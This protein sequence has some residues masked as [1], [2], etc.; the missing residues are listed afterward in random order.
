MVIKRYFAMTD[1]TGNFGIIGGAG[2]SA[3]STVV[4]RQEV[5]KEFADLKLASDTR[6]TSFT[7]ET[8]PVE[9]C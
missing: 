2:N 8:V 9:S 3:E 4:N 5:A 7:K 1:P 6:P